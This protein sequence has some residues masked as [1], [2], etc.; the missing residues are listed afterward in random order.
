MSPAH[1]MPEED[2]RLIALA[3]PLGILAA[4][5][6]LTDTLVNRV[7]VRS[8]SGLAHTTLVEISEIGRFPR[9]LAAICAMIALGTALLSFLR[10][11][12]YASISRRLLI[13]GFAGIFLPAVALA[14]V[15]P[16]ERN[17]QEMVIIGIG[18]A[19]VLGVLI[20]LSALRRPAPRGIRIGL[21]L[22]TCAALLSFGALVI[23]VLEASV[24]SRGLGAEVL[25]DSWQ[26]AYDSKGLLKHVGELAYL[27]APIAVGA[28]LISRSANRIALVLAGVTAVG[29]LIGFVVGASALGGD[30]SVVLYG[31]QRL[32]LL[33]A[34]PQAYLPLVAFALGL[35]IFATASPTPG[36]RQI[37]AALLL[38]IAAGY[39]PQT[40]AS[41]LMM[42]LGMTLCA[43][44]CIALA[45]LLPAKNDPSVAP[46]PNRRVNPDLD[47]P[48]EEA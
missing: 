40:P 39:A 28:T 26:L 1:E 30:F 22:L 15:L 2:Q 14:T 44:A 17:R 5:M 42:V 29:C 25:H 16:A 10:E 41:L 31:A 34:T 4:W 19:N 46:R 9:N 11:P 45:P 7:F 24:L 21:G 23:T 33:E 32:E 20:G 37:G 27:A 8:M 3:P 12:R 13:A 18:A 38:V 47:L 35:A 43:R 36:H 6:A 48:E